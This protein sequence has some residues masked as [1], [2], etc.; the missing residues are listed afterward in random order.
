M[1]TIKIIISI[2]VLFILQSVFGGLISIKGCVPELLLCFTVCFAVQDSGR[3][4]VYVLI[5][6]GILSG[7]CVGR[8]FPVAVLTIGAAGLI[9]CGAASRLRFIPMAVRTVV[10]IAVC[11]PLMNAAEY[12]VAYKAMTL[13]V[14]VTRILPFT[15]YTAVCGGIMYPA[16]KQMMFK[17]TQKKLLIV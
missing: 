4:S 3:A 10:I 2:L 12:F 16:V 8:V 1:R 9:A 14:L 5:A 13:T 7:S 11:A 17:K 15:I 6:C